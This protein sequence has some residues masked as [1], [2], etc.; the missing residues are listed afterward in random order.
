VNINPTTI[1]LAGVTDDLLATFDKTAVILEER[2]TA[3]GQGGSWK[4]WHTARTEACRVVPVVVREFTAAG[5]N[6]RPVGDL[7]IL[8]RKEATITTAHRVLV[9]G[10][11]WAVVSVTPRHTHARVVLGGVL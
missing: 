7:E 8:V 5:T 10:K 2:E 9:E 11:T 1:E 3:D 6:Y 4:A